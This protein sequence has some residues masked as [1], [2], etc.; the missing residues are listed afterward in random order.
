MFRSFKHLWEE[1]PTRVVSSLM[2]LVPLTFGLL[3]AFG[4]VFSDEQQG[5]ISE[6]LLGVAVLFGLGGE[7]IRSQV[8]PATK[9][10]QAQDDLLALQTAINSIKHDG[11]RDVAMD[12]VRQLQTKPRP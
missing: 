12:Q 7:V 9:V 3:A 11:R 1:N 10:Y 6:F 8:S 5:A 4:V 2:A